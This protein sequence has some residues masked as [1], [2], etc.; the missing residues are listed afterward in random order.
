MRFRNEFYLCHRPL[1]RVGQ[2]V[3]PA[4]SVAEAAGGKHAHVTEVTDFK[5]I[6]QKIEIGNQSVV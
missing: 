4:V 2:G 1:Q 3:P 6:K 5:I